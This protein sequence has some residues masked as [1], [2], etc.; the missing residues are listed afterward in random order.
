MRVHVLTAIGIVA[1]AGCAGSGT[2]TAGGSAPTGD[3]AALATRIDEIVSEPIKAGKAA[4]GSIAVIKGGD[5]IAVKGFG[6]ANVE[7]GVPTMPGAIYEIGSITKQF[8]GAAVM[9]LVEQGKLSLDDDIRKHLPSY[10]TKGRKITV[11]QLLDHT[12]GIKGYTEMPEARD[13]FAK[14]LPRDTLVKLFSKRPLEFEPGDEQIYNNSAFFLAGLIIERVSGMSYEDYVQKNLFD[15]AGMKDSHYCSERKIHKNKV[16]GYDTDSSGMVQRG[17]IS[18]QWPYAAGSLCASAVDLARWNQALHRDGKILGPEAYQE[19][20]K[21]DTLN[22]G[23]RLGYAKGIAVTDRLGRRA[24]HH[25]GGINGFLSENIYFPDDSLTVV[26][27][28]NTAGPASPDELALKIAEQVLGPTKVAALG[29]EGD[30]NAFAG[31]YAGLGRGQSMEVTV[32]ADNGRLTAKLPFADSAKALTY[33]G[34]NT[35]LQDETKFIF[36]EHNGRSTLRID[37]GYGNNLLVKK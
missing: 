25:G 11:R 26:V 3:R 17:P 4:G 36:G 29:F 6:M 2:G 34:E 8:T 12:S 28:F 23:V 16:T 35:F 22:S 18:H 7:L 37:A 1:A 20:I 13:L 30:L 32:T 24:L 27:L 15:R 21:A 10:D 5:T 33:I 31:T 14:Q 9:Q 19:F